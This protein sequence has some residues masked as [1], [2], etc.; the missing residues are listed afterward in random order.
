VSPTYQDVEAVIADV[1]GVAEASVTAVEGSA[2]G[3]LRI[4]LSRGHDAG[5]VS[6]AVAA[7]LHDRLGL[8]IDPAS[9]RPRAADDRDAGDRTPDG[10]AE[11]G[12]AGP[13]PAT[14]SVDEPEAGEVAADEPPPAAVEDT[15]PATEPT[16]GTAGEPPVARKVLP[17][18]DELFRPTS[19]ERRPVATTNGDPHPGAARRWHRPVIR[20]LALAGHGLEIE[21][22][23]ALDV[24]GSEVRGRATGP[25][26][27]RSTFR[28]I[29]RATLDA[30]E[31]MCA[32]EVRTELE[33]VE[34]VD[35]GEDE[36]V[37]VTITFL[38]HDG[39]DRLIGVSIS[40]GDAEQ[41]VMRATLDA[42][43]RRVGLLLE[44]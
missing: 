41:A 22:E 30:V 8:D 16:A 24:D 11:D 18:V 27:R 9:I 17:G 36:R 13:E 26:T 15:T 37:T 32:G 34:L 14:G 40:R 25:A 29:A 19:R 43:N 39:A 4:R 20:D 44:D 1:P 42:V 28:A 6:R 31:T 38:T 35:D 21:A 33:Q 12:A 3:R 10:G 7:A 5:E 23:V 2:R